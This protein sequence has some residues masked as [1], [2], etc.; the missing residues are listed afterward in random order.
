MSELFS[1]FMKSYL[2]TLL[3]T[4]GNAVRKGLELRLQEECCEKGNIA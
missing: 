1:A 2:F 4:R 3:I